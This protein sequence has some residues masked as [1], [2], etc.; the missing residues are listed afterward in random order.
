MSLRGMVGRLRRE[1]TAQHGDPASRAAAASALALLAERGV[2]GASPDEWH[3]L[4]PLST[5][6]PLF[7]GEQVPVSPSRL[8]RFEES[9]LDW[10]LETIAGSQPTTSMSVGTILH[11]AMETA[12]DPSVEAIWAAVE[13]RWNELLFESP[14]LAEY[15]R[16]ASRV[17]AAGIA[18]YLRDFEGSGAQLV[19]AESRFSFDVGPATVN[20]SI[21]RVER[22]ADGEVVIV[23]LKTGT[24]ITQQARIDEHPQLGVYQLAYREGLL[25]EFLEELGEHKPG[26][27]KLL[28][29]KKGANGRAYREG[30]QAPLDDAGLEAFRERIRRVAIG[31]AAA[32]FEGVLELRSY[33]LG[34]VP[35]LRLHRVGAVSGD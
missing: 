14:W 6:R 33:G 8:E 30:V 5:D 29:V 19:G 25:D 13:S 2:P 11:W 23:D 21:D 4:L 17:L 3:G 27:A 24:P 28:Y 9:P 34:N 32:Q 7:E 16:R 31:M 12:T 15:Q 20:G 10:F 35:Q 22:S 26:G 1:L 18:E